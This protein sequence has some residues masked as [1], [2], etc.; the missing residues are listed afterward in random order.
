[1]KLGPSKW[2]VCG[3]KFEKTGKRTYFLQLG[4]YSEQTT[5]WFH[6]ERLKGVKKS[7]LLMI[8][9]LS[10][11]FWVC[12]VVTATPGVRIGTNVATSAFLIWQHRPKTPKTIKVYFPAP[13]PHQPPHSRTGR[14]VSLLLR[15]QIYAAHTEKQVSS[16]EPS[17]TYRSIIQVTTPDFV[18]WNFM[19][20]STHK[21]IVPRSASYCRDYFQWLSVLVPHS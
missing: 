16:Q 14:G 1:M 18:S 8:H 21:Q 6:G 10:L 2:L 5:S 7:I 11:M 4:L 20:P 15:I 12:K 13:Y 19:N 3:I 9:V 17:V